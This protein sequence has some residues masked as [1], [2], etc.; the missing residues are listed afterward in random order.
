MIDARQTLECFSVR[1]T[2]VLH[3]V[4]GALL[5][6]AF[7]LAAPVLNRAGSSSY[8]TLLLC[9]PL[10][11]VP[12]EGGVLLVERRRIG[13]SWRS[14]TAPRASPRLSILESLLTV[15]ALYSTSMA[16]TVLAAPARG[17]IFRAVVHWLP[18]WPVVDGLPEGI[19]P[20][21]LW[22]G[23]VFSGLVAPIIEEVYFRG[24]LMPRIPAADVWAPAVN[25]ALF[26]I[27]HFFAPWNYVSIFVAFLP[28]AYYVRLKGK[29]LPAIIT[30]CLFNSVGIVVALVGLS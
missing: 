25:A 11:L 29:L 21:T 7:L 3:L 27:Y 17:V 10:I 23:L 20:S 26:S 30:H 24:F 5:T 15:A 6:F 22:L 12:V 4:P 19:S 14:L 9:I 8:L 28:L 18:R 2:L 13:F 1:K 16:A